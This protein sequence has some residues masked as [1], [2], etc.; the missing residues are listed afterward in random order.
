MI[1]SKI[2]II[3]AILAA[4][5]VVVVCIVTGD[6]FF[7]MCVKLVISIPVF[8]IIGLF[9]RFYLNRKVFYKETGDEKTVEAEEGEDSVG[10]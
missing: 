4:I 2:Q 6:T 9:A 1:R 10:A 3:L 8:Y 5:A 7:G